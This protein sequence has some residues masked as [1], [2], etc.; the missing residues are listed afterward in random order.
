MKYRIEKIQKSVPKEFLLSVFFVFSDG[1]FSLEVE[2]VNVV[3]Q[4]RNDLAMSNLFFQQQ[5]A[6]TIQF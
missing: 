1:S 2:V 3:C 4:S 6:H 5:H